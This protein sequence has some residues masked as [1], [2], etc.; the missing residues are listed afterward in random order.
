MKAQHSIAQLCSALGVTRSGYHA[1][2]VA[3]ESRRTLSDTVL[4]GDIRQ[5]HASQRGRY[6][7]PRIRREL[8]RRGARHG[9][10]RIARLMR[11]AGLQG[12]RAQRS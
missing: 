10:K 3:P 9:T 4:L 12:R 2:Q 6:G 7:A 1:W 8:G 11:Q 5:V